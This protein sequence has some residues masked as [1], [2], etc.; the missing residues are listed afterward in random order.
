MVETQGGG[1]PYLRTDV[2][3]PVSAIPAFLAEALPEL[4][5]RFTGSRA[6]AYGHV[7]DGN[8][9]LN[10]IP[11]PDMTMQARTALLHAAEDVIFTILDRHDGS[12]SAE[13]GIGRAKRAAFLQRIDPVARAM[14]QGLKRLLDPDG[15]LSM[16]R[17]LPSD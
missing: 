7:G 16:G 11:P 15:I 6:L 4:H 5:T 9:H 3:L 14:A 10:L 17:I 1:A 2:S 8:I 13:H 12:I